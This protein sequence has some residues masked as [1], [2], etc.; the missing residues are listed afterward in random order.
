MLLLK[1]FE[2]CTQL[3]YLTLNSD[4]T[5]D[6]IIKLYANYILLISIVTY[7]DVFLQQDIY[8]QKSRMELDII[9]L[10]LIEMSLQKRDKLLQGIL[11]KDYE[12]KHFVLWNNARRRI[13]RGKTAAHEESK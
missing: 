8:R 9:H 13:V 2:M 5:F 11:M 4:W 3:V 12:G 1:T 7:Y 6:A 10:Q